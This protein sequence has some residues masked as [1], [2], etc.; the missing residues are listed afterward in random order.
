MPDIFYDESKT[1]TISDSVHPHV[2][3][4][5][6]ENQLLLLP[7]LNRLHYIRTLSLA[8][9]VFPGA[10]GSRFGHSIG[11]MQLASKIADQ[12]ISSVI[13]HEY[14]D[15]LFPGTSKSSKD[16]AR[17]IEAVRLAALLHD[18]GH[19]PFS[20]SSELFMQA[21][22]RRNDVELKEYERLFPSYQTTG[23]VHAHEYYS[24][25]IIKELF[26][27]HAIANNNFGIE[28]AD[29]TCLLS[30]NMETTELFPT[31]NSLAIFRKVISSQIDADRMDYLMR[32]SLY[33]G[34]GFGSIDAERLISNIDVVKMDDRSFQ[35][36][37]HEKALGNVENFLDSRYKMYKW[38][39]RHHFMLAV[40]QLLKMA[41]YDMLDTGDLSLGDFDWRRYLRGQ[42]SDSMILGIIENKMND[43]NCFYRGLLD[44]RYAP[45]SILKGRMDNYQKFEDDLR[46]RLKSK[47]SESEITKLIYRFISNHNAYLSNPGQKAGSGMVLDD[48]GTVLVATVIH[49]APFETAD[50]EKKIL[51]YDGAKTAT[52]MSSY[53][54]YFNSLNNEWNNFRP[55]HFAYLVPGMQKTEYA[56]PDYMESVRSSLIDQI[57]EEGRSAE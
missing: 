29:V 26:Q 53:S 44:R 6:L 34:V 35:L 56:S 2:R 24:I 43:Q 49:D 50:S 57:A 17:I 36:V 9:L 3:I 45:A 1:R 27:E 48:A 31:K 46:S 5:E 37:F 40:D 25:Q 19:G 20:H 32:D 30:H 14:F 7:A 23:E 18:V 33:T 28:P 10:S 39:V 4:T 11:T 42:T 52:E 15:E 51:I 47:I 54:S 55:Y 16:V 22:I 21:N 8:H 38:V 41:M 13:R 12:V